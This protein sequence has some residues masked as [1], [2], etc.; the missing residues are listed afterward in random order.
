MSPEF[1]E[2]RPP[3]PG[4][5]AVKSGDKEV[6]LAVNIPR[7]EAEP[8]LLDGQEMLAAVASDPDGQQKVIEGHKVWVAA[9]NSVRERIESGQKLGWYLL[10]A[11]LALLFAEHVLANNTSRR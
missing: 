6:K 1:P 4:I 10:L 5:Y 11:L 9:S 2:F 7:A 8:A 3:M